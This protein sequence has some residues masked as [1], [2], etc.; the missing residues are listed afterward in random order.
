MATAQK[1]KTEKGKAEAVIVR[2]GIKPVKNSAS[3]K[4]GSTKPSAVMTGGGKVKSAAASSEAID[5]SRTTNQKA[6]KTKTASAAPKSAAKAKTGSAASKPAAKT[7]AKGVQASATKTG[8]AKSAKM[9]A[10]K[11]ATKTATAGS[12]AKPKAKPAATKTNKK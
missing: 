1:A 8:M 11:V 5:T 9:A 4:G 3:A 12:R 2:P 6:S 10:P 7:A